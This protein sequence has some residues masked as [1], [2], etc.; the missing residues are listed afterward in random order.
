MIFAKS[1]YKSSGV[2]LG[3]DLGEIVILGAEIS[4]LIG[5]QEKWESP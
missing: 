3:G 4:P 1:I 2:K 5:A